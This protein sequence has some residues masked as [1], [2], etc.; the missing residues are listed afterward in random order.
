MGATV[1]R[2][3]LKEKAM[4]RN[5]DGETDTKRY[6]LAVADVMLS[7]RAVFRLA[8]AFLFYRPHPVICE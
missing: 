4:R 8:L 3:V 1:R 2:R 5:K 6:S 7:L